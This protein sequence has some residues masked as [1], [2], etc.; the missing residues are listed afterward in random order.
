[1]V[2]PRRSP[3]F[4]RLETRGGSDRGDR[5]GGPAP[6]RNPLSVLF[7]ARRRDRRSSL[8]LADS[9]QRVVSTDAAPRAR[10]P[11]RNVTRPA[12]GRQVSGSVAARAVTSPCRRATCILVIR[13]ERASGHRPSF[14][15]ALFLRKP[16]HTWQAVSC[17]VYFLKFA[18]IELQ[19]C[20]D[21]RIIHRYFLSRNNSARATDQPNEKANQIYFSKKFFS[22]PLKTY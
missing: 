10:A 18:Q 9:L 17:R 12:P 8:S 13:A 14:G 7:T 3:P 11:P 2:G 5:D 4:L 16:S 15:A 19:Q 21:A 20:V 22:L 6:N 1:M